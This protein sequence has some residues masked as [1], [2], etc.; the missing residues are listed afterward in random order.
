MNENL[1]RSFHD[2]HAKILELVTQDL[3]D[4]N[5]LNALV[6]QRESIIEEITAA[7]LG[8]ATLKGLHE[9]HQDLVSGLESAKS[10]AARRIGNILAG[11]KALKAYRS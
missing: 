7:D 2:N 9:K 8:E 11:R 10:E 4:I 1:L 6:V 3:F 5:Q